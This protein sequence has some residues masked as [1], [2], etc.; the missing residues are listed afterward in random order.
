MSEYVT[1]VVQ[2]CWYR[3]VPPIRE[4]EIDRFLKEGMRGSYLDV[5]IAVSRKLIIMFQFHRN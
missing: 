4:R 3:G 2:R 5:S 1:D